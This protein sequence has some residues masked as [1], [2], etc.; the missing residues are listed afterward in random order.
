MFI[1]K[2][3]EMILF[4]SLSTSYTNRFPQMS[5]RI[6]LICVKRLVELNT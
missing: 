3:N 6:L 1:L 2:K 4:P 5:R